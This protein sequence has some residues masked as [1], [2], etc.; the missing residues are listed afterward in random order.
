MDKPLIKLNPEEAG[1]LLQVYDGQIQA[2][3]EWQKDAVKTLKENLEDLLI[4]QNQEGDDRRIDWW[5]RRIDQ[6]ESLIE[7]GKGE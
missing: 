1:E 6:Q 5:I 4:R 3:K 7:S 2:L